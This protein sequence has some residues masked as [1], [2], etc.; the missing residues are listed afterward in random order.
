MAVVW[1]SSG[2]EL[3]KKLG[4]KQIATSTLASDFTKRL[5]TTAVLPFCVYFTIFTLHFGLVPNSGDHDL[6]ISPQLKYSLNG[7]EFEP[8]QQG[9]VTHVV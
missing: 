9:T 3:W 6:L 4:D 8:T 5:I 2:I 1:L 7:N